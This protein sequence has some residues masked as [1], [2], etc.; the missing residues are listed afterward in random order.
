M[1]RHTLCIRK[2]P[3]SAMTWDRGTLIDGSR[4]LEEERKKAKEGSRCGDGCGVS[5]VVAGDV[6]GDGLLLCVSYCRA[7]WP[8]DV[9]G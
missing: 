9:L 1:D 7:S 2:K 6:L 4:M 8:L 3:F 5:V